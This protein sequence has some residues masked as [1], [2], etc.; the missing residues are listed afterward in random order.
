MLLLRLH[1][2]LDEER[3]MKTTTSTGG[4]IASM[5]VAMTRCHSGWCRRR[6]SM[7]L[8]PMTMVSSIPSSV[9]ISS[10]QRYWFQP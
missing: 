2:A 6:S 3:C 4:S 1:Q 7:R 8:M 5:V 10:G 9:V